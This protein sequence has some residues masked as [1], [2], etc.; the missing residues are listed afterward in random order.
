MKRTASLSLLTCVTILALLLG[1]LIAAA[2]GP[3]P[4]KPR[5]VT[6]A[7]GPAQV[8][9]PVPLAASAPAATFIY[10]N[11]PSIPI[12]IDDSTTCGGG[13]IVRAFSVTD[14][15]TVVNVKVGFNADHSYRGDIRVS[16]RS[17]AG[18]QVE[19]I[20]P[21]SA[22]S[23]ADYDLM[24]SDA[25]A[26]PIDDLG[27]DITAIPYYDRD[28]RPRHPFSAFSGQ[29]S[30]GTWT[31]LIC[32]AYPDLHGTYNRSR[33]VLESPPAGPA[34]RVSKTAD[35]LK[36]VQDMVITYSVAVQNVGLTD[37]ADTTLTDSIPAGASYVPDSLS[38][39]GNPPAVFNGSAI[40]WTGT[41]GGG[42]RTVVTYQVKVTSST[43]F[44][45]N[46]ATITHASLPLALQPSVVSQ[47]FAGQDLLYTDETDHAIPDDECVTSAAAQINVSDNFTVFGVRVGINLD[48]TFRGDISATLRSPSG[49]QVELIGSDPQDVYENYDILL[50]GASSNSL[51]DNIDDN[52]GV[53]FYERSVAPANPLS[54]F[55]GENAGG[56][57]TLSVCDISSSDDGTLRQWSLFFSTVAPPAAPAV[58]MTKSGNGVRLTWPHVTTDTL[59]NSVTVTSYEVWRS[60]KPYFV[61]NPG[62]PATIRL[63]DALPPFG[64]TVSTDD[65][66]VLT[67]GISYY[68]LIRAVAG[69][70]VSA[71]SNQVG[72]FISEI[73]PGGL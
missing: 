16:L 27:D 7:Q 36:V 54:V 33:L 69:P 58:T 1:G 65:G 71:S 49:T 8:L 24:L 20:N 29:N 64:S 30:A 17:P 37:A 40:T 38:T 52:I 26:N 42:Q 22:N 23:W 41:V 12:A 62:D 32:D 60:T 47:V 43:G 5:K 39:Q 51:H 4:R 44:I 70:S 14:S 28:A 18:T 34:L 9:N 19:I 2:E 10:D 11:I 57:W 35:R 45:I 46:T 15:F 13:E 73:V 61:P 67:G 56:A 50:D 21:T 31:L 25:S 6:T 63:P 59:G 48:H 66:G 3:K 55:A 53:P 68:Y 72:T